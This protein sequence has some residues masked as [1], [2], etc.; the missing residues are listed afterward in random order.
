MTNL[1]YIQ[2]LNQEPIPEMV[3]EGDGYKYIPKSI[4]QYELLKIYNGHT[5]WEMI[6]DI[7]GKGGLWGTGVLKVKHPVSGE[8]LSNTGTASLK[9]DK[10]MKLNY[11]N[12]ESQCFKNACK[13]LGK[14]FGQTLNLEVDDAEPEQTDIEGGVN[15]DH[16]ISTQKDTIMD[17]LQSFE[18]K[19][20]A[21]EYLATTSF[22]HLIAAKSLIKNKPTKN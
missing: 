2:A 8:W 12:L 16:T 22:K 14:W 10:V 1:E 20:D 13:K 21:E 15:E 11:P 5:Q 3:K 4:L 18:F 17:K 9:H 19:E 6:R 7:V